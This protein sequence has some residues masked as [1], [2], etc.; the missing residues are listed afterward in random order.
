MLKRLQDEYMRTSAIVRAECK[1]NSETQLSITSS[2]MRNFLINYFLRPLEILQELSIQYQITKKQS[3]YRFI[4]QFTN[5]NRIHIRFI[6]TSETINEQLF[7]NDIF[8]KSKFK[9]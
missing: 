8:F 7:N 2:L 4:Q 1:S 5:T 9:T 3:Q 6:L